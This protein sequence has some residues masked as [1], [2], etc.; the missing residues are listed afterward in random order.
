MGTSDEDLQAL[1]GGLNTKIKVIGCGGGGSNTIFRLQQAAIENCELVAVNTDAQHLLNIKVPTK[2][3]IGRA[4]TRGL[5]AGALP[6]IGEKSALEADSDIRKVLEGADMVFITAG[7]GGGTGTGSAP[8]VAKIAR[9]MGALTIAVVT[10]PFKVE[11]AVRMEN[12]EAGLARLREAADTTIVIPNDK[13]LEIAP[14]L[15]LQA[16]FRV[17]DEVLMRSIRGLTEMITKPGIVNLDFADLNTVMKKA[18]VAMIGLGESD[19]ENRARDAVEEAL[20]S[21]LLDVDISHA[22]GCLVEVTGGTDMTLAEAQEAVQLVHD[23]IGPDARIIWG[24]SVNHAMGRNVRVMV[25]VTGVR[26]RQVLGP[27][28]AQRGAGVPAGTSSAGGSGSLPPQSK[29]TLVRDPRVATN[30]VTAR[31]TK[32]ADVD[33]VI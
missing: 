32:P 3:L 27:T 10:M 15:P 33:F 24:S 1:I 2:V 31:Q 19:S 25:V 12:A 18:G 7:M 9:E 21:P 17:A 4:T 28:A 26:S 8:V 16:A 30:A 29:P 11:G 22:S 13:L 14:N 5:G 6:Q 20:S 23:R